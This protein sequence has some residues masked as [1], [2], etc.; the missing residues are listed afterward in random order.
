VRLEIPERLNPEGE[1][2]V[3]LDEEAVRKATAW[4]RAL[5]WRINLVYPGQTFDVAIPIE[6][7][8]GRPLTRDAVAAAAEELHRRNEEARLIEARSQERVVRG[9]RL[10]A[11]GAVDQP[12]EV[13]LEPGELPEP[14]SRR[15]VHTGD[16]W[17]D[18][19]PIYDGD[20]LK[21]GAPVTGPA[22]VQSKFTTIV[23]GT[24]DM[25]DVLPNGDVLIEVAA[26]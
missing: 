22:L 18:D 3:E 11:T 9:I 21:P 12:N 23:L 15:R 8:V 24:G 6:K 20:A 16:A 17:H 14:M 26:Q 4:R 25:A 10:I 2:D 13:T 7:E 19:V 1:V 5:E